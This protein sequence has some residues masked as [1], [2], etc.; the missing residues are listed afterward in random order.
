MSK[1]KARQPAKPRPSR[2]AATEAGK[3]RLVELTEDDLYRIFSGIEPNPQ[4]RRRRLS[5]WSGR[6]RLLEQL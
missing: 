2:E 5:R 4:D 1:R 6:W 3:E